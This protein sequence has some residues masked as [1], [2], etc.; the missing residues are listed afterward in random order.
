MNNGVKEFRINERIVVRDYDDIPVE[1]RTRAVAKLC[2]CI[3]TI[4]DKLFSE[5]VGEFV[6][7]IHFDEYELQSKKIWRADHLMPYI[8]KKAEYG[9]TLD[10]C[11]NVVV[12]IITENGK[13][14]GRGHG[15]ILH[16][17]TFGIV[18]AA[19]YGLKK[20]YEKMNGGSLL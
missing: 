11:D 5:S 6:Y 3:G 8:E 19:S 1:N 9:C 15:H 12:V 16:E 18:Q 10:I 4:V 20:I 7:V 2:G 17:G 13:E 14:I